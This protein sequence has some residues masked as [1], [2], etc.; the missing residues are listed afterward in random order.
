[1][2]KIII[3]YFLIQAVPYSILLW[4][5]SNGKQRTFLNF[6]LYELFIGSQISVPDCFALLTIFLD[7][8]S[9]LCVFLF[10]V[11]SLY[12]FLE[13]HSSHKSSAG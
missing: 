13:N 1:M 8:I 12:R 7:D 2:K 9:I 11:I 10:G 3:F 5:V 6:H 4:L